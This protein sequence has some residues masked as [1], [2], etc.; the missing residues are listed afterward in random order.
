MITTLCTHLSDRE[1]GIQLWQQFVDSTVITA[2]EKL[3]LSMLKHES[4]KS[5]LNYLALRV[6]A[7]RQEVHVL[8][9]EMKNIKCDVGLM[10]EKFNESLNE[11]FGIIQRECLNRIAA[12]KSECRAEMH[13]AVDELSAKYNQ[14]KQSLESTIIS[15]QKAV[16]DEKDNMTKLLDQL[17]TASIAADEAKQVQTAMLNDFDA[18]RRQ[19]NGKLAK[20][21]EEIEQLR[22]LLEEEKANKRMELEAMESK[23]NDEFDEIEAK[24]KHSMK[25]LIASKNK[26]IEE[27]LARAKDAEQV[28]ADLKATVLPVIS[29]AEDS[30]EK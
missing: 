8:K 22:K 23:M 27:A 15:L 18:E 10:M 28:V 13:D 21:G 14:E 16:Q 7:A 4:A 17:N 29:A 25:L 26:E 19:L 3:S 12:A 11:L 20:S 9:D 6:S 30:G 24:V 1:D 5:T 2:A